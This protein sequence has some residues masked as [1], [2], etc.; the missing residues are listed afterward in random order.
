MKI[1]SKKKAI[2]RINVYSS[3]SVLWHDNAR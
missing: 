1:P 2:L 3:V